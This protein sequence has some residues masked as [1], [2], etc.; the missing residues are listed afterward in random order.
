MS[1]TKAIK[2]VATAGMLGF[3]SFGS[4]SSY[5]EVTSNLLIGDKLPGIVAPS[6]PAFLDGVSVS[7]SKVSSSTRVL[8]ATYAAD[9]GTQKLVYPNTV[10]SVKD[11]V[12]TLNAKFNSSNV[13]QSGTVSMQG[14]I[15]GLGI[16]TLQTLMTADLTAFGKGY[17][18]YVIGFNTNNIKCNPLINAYSQCTTAES[19]TM[20]LGKSFN[21]QTDY[22]AK[23]YALTS[24]PVPAAV[25]LFGSGLMGLVGV[26]RRKKKT[27]V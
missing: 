26:A 13:F 4:A 27:S 2:A 21:F 22:K 7:Y 23:G 1:T 11:T 17:D 8:T 24:V 5:A 16:N 10:F 12:Y 19:I 15:G 20:A 6:L 18:G 9:L 14:K 3:L 25:W